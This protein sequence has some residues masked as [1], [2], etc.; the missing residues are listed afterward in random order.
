MLIINYF[1]KTKLSLNQVYYLIFYECFVSVVKVRDAHLEIL[2]WFLLKPIQVIGGVWKNIHPL[3]LR[4]KSS[5]IARHI[6][7]IG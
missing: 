5:I 4:E 6:L 7:T 3:V 2:V 1:T